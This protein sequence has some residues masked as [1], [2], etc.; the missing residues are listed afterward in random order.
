M[1]GNDTLGLGIQG[2]GGPTLQNQ[3]IGAYASD[4]LYIGMF[5]LNPASTNF[6]DTDK[7]QPSYM[8]TLKDKNMIPSLSFGYTA[9]NQYR[10]K[11]VLGSLTLGGYDSARF[12]PN[13]LSIPFATDSLRQLQVGIQSVSSLNENGTGTTLSSGGIMANVDSTVPQIWLPVEACKAFEKAFGLTFDEDSQLYLVSS[14]QHGR[15]QRQNTSVTF[16]LGTTAAGGQTQNIT[17]PYDSFDLLVQPPTA[18]VTNNTRYFPLRRAANESQYTLGRTFLQ[19]AYLIVDWER[20]NFSISQCEFSANMPSQLVPI[21]STS[22]PSSG[23]SSGKTVGIAVGV[24]VAILA[25][26]FAILVYF[27]IKRRNRKRRDAE[28]AKLDETPPEETIRRGYGKGELGTGIDNQRY[29]MVGSEPPPPKPGSPGSPSQWV[30]EK[31]QYPGDRAGMAEAP[32][33]SASVSEL[34]S[35]SGGGYFANARPLHEMYDPSTPEAG[36]A[37]LPAESPR[38]ELQGSNPPS[39]A[40][41]PRQKPTPS[42]P[43]SPVSQSSVGRRSFRDRLSKRPTPSR[44]STMESLPSPASASSAPSAPTP[45]KPGRKDTASSNDTFS[46]VSREGTFTP[47]NG[48]SGSGRSSQ[49]F[50]PVSPSSPEGTQGRLGGVGRFGGF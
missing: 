28:I 31:A 25:V 35:K 6:S 47:E 43:L 14:A 37:E 3:I 33:A 50:S 45:K 24:V 10:E 15:L 32:G 38:G 48:G 46:P 36:P 41:S 17:L 23:S 34:P 11:Q 40:T 29:E 21:Q 12:T 16:T 26:A 39:V 19:E 30:D 18:G 8:S 42:A 13:N 44:S 27:L 5:G 49:P 1:F 22:P 20:Q 7:D 2:S 9:G 4:E